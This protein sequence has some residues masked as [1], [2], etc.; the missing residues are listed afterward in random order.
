M[1]AMTPSS[2]QP[3][4]A[5]K[6][7]GVE[8]LGDVPEHWRMLPHRAIFYEVN[9]RDF[10]REEMLSVTITWGVIQQ[11]ALLEGSSKKDSSR[12]DKSAYKLVRPDDIAYNKMRAWQGAIGASEYRGIVSPAYVVQRPRK[13]FSARYLHHLLRT[14]AF[15]KEAERWSYGITS[16]M[17]SL[18]PQHFRMI[19]ACVPPHSEQAAIVRYL[20]YVDRRIR[21][22]VAAKER[23]IFLLEEEKQAVINR[24]VTRGL[25]PNVPLKPSGVEWLGDVPE[26][27]E[28]RRLRSCQKRYG[29]GRHTPHGTHRRPVH[30][31]SG[32]VNRQHC[33]KRHALRRPCDELTG[34]PQ[35]TRIRGRAILVVRS[36]RTAYRVSRSLKQIRVNP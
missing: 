17:W 2:L 28:V 29:V 33:R 30:P 32:I 4:S 26:H 15:A 20:D 9:E 27:W 6:P 36:R 34:H 16:D 23:L 8:W 10:P 12:L 25:D 22:Y 5:Y 31:L 18:R 24:A 35:A 21:R 19:Y 3:Y 13:K 7:S 11:T 1:T 14:P